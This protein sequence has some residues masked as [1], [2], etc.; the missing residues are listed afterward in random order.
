MKAHQRFLV[1]LAAGAAVLLGQANTGSLSGLVLDSSG[2]AVTGA[3]VTIKN[4]VT[5]AG[6]EAISSDAG[7]Y[8]FPSLQ[9]GPY[10]IT[11]EQPGFK[12]LS[13]SGINIAIA[14]RSAL[15]LALEVGDIQQAVTITADAPLLATAT[16]EGGTQF[17]PQFMRD[18]PLFVGGNIRNPMS[19]VSFMPG[20]NNGFQEGSI[21]GSS[22]R[23]QEILIDGASQVNTESGGVSFQFGSPEQFG[24]FRLLTNSFSAEYGRTGG[25][26]Q[27]YTTKSGANDLHGS[28]FWFLRNDKF[29]AAGWGVNSRRVFGSGDARNP[30]K[31]KVRQHEFGYAVGGPV[32]LPKLYDGRNRTFFYTTFNGFE[33][34][35]GTA[36]GNATIATQLMRQ[37]DFSELPFAIYDPGTNTATNTRTAFGGNRIPQARFSAV[38]RGIVPLIPAPTSPGFSGNYVTQSFSDLSRR[39]FSLK[40]DHAFSDKNRINGFWSRQLT[41]SIALAGLPDPLTAGGQSVERPY[42]YRV[43]H[44]YSFT[45]TLLNNLTF[46][47]TIFDVRGERAPKQIATN[48]PNTLGLRGVETGT[49]ASFPFVNFTNGFSSWGRIQTRN[50]Q[51]NWTYHLANTVSWIRGKHEFKFGGEWRRL[52]TFQDPADDALV[53][54]QFDFANFQTAGD[55]AGLRTTTGHSF[56]S[57]L[58][59]DTQQ[60]VRIINAAPAGVDILYGHRSLFVQDNW[61]LTRKLTLN[62]GLRWDVGLPRWDQNGTQATFDRVRRNPAA[63]NV[64]GALSFIGFGEGRLNKKRFGDIYLDDFGP[65]AGFAYQ[66]R[67]KTVLRGG[68]GL[69]YSP[70]N[71]LIG[72]SCFPCSF[73]RS[74]RPERLSPDSFRPALNWDGGFAPPPGFIPP[75]TIAPDAFNNQSVTELVAEDGRHARIHQWSFDIQ[76]EL[77]GK[78]LFDISYV[79]SYSDRMNSRVPVN[80]VD[81]RRLGLGALLGRNITDPAVAAAG[82]SRPYPSFTGTLAQA[83]RPYPQYLDISANYTALGSSRYNGM[84]LKVER[85]YS[86]FNLLGSYV[87]SRAQMYRGADASN[88][89]CIQPADAYNYGIERSLHT[90]DIPHTVNLI[91][92]WDL[93]FGRGQK[94]LRGGSRVIDLLAGGWTLSGLAQYRSGNLL[95]VNLPNALAAGVLFARNYRASVTGQSFKTGA[96]RTDLD[97]NNPSVRWLDRAA[98]GIP[99]PFTF[100]NAAQFYSAVRNPRVL[101]ENLGIVKRTRFAEGRDFEIRADLSNL[102]NRTNFGGINTTLNDPNFGRPTGVMTGPRIVQMAMRVNF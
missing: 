88:C 64:A 10:T 67:A 70:S 2:A 27:V 21:L 69:F 22:R 93:P 101:T 83:L 7:S 80:Q 99:A 25:G 97:P 100:G 45:P 34:A 75:P 73:G 98:F 87:F 14:T 66:L 38:S 3:K 60:A 41:D 12:K 85:R 76:H 31:P 62:L 61:R 51:A 58:L 17:Q 49:S 24:E 37:G 4:D 55:A 39:F 79:G 86:D 72:G 84:I 9:P 74:S 94:F 50:H 89:G 18:A 44:I 43:N 102:F 54:G 92:T 56:A 35:A 36:V 95:T 63:G 11:V 16:S 42:I 1:S 19:F 13:Q 15:N 59:G 96:G 65:R 48:W 52:R 30:R 82:F 78:L 40:I 8:T 26:I 77:P 5:G 20:V 53:H 91:A 28:V 57:F 23:S 29:E 46:G 81:P 33:Q 68:Y 71:G 6:Q 90:N 47:F 32:W